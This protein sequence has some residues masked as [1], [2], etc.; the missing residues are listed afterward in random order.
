M[1]SIQFLTGK[2]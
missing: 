1:C 2:D